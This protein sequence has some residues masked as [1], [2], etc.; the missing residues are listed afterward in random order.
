MKK[1]LLVL[2]LVVTTIFALV[3]CGSDKPTGVQVN[4]T[5][6]G[7]EEKTYSVDL[8][9]PEGSTLT[10]ED[11]SVNSKT[12]ANA[13]AGYTM[14]AY[15]FQ[16]SNYAS[17]KEINSGKDDYSEFKVGEYEAYGYTEMFTYKVYALLEQAGETYVYIYFVVD[18]YNFSLDNPYGSA[19]YQNC[20]EA[21]T[22]V[23]SVVFNGVVE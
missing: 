11:E 16:D 4:L 2:L 15:L 19:L 13:D 10:V 22:I 17:N 7:Y 9:Y 8:Y 18:Q 23:N 14:T 12:F 1:K 21:Q 3:G 5:Y 20:Q 6:K